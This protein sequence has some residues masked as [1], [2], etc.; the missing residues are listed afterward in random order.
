MHATCGKRNQ[1]NLAGDHYLFDR[2]YL[3]LCEFDAIILKTLEIVRTNQYY[4]D[5]LCNNL[6]TSQ[7][8]RSR[9]VILKFNFVK[10]T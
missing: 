8:L 7:I 10:K 2:V 3:Y 4:V 1:E 6:C 5:R 9:K